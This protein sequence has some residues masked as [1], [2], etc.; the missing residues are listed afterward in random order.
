MPT[1]VYPRVCGGTFWVLSFRVL[2]LGLSPRV[3]GNHQ[4]RGWAQEC[5]RSIPACAGE[6]T[7]DR[8]VDVLLPVYPRVCGG[9]R[10]AFCM[11]PSFSGL[12]P[13]VRGNHAHARSLT[14]YA[15]SI[16]ACAGEPKSCRTGYQLERVY[17][18]VCGGTNRVLAE[19]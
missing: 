10:N 17:P 4:G 12:S 8:E 7:P 5:V 16:P 9:T 2:R 19:L 11:R 15:R 14:Q 1:G 6:P 3:R 18:R 13:R